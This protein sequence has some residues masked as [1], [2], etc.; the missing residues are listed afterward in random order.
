MRWQLL[1]SSE[2]PRYGGG[3]TAPLEDEE[4]WHIPGHVAVVL[5]P[6]AGEA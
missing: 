2:D 6:A 4:N 5:R 1:W 3:G